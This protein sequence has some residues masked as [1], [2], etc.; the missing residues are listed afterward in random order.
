MK[1]KVIMQRIVLFAIISLIINFATTGQTLRLVDQGGTPGSYPTISAAVAAANPGD[2]IKVLSGIYPESVVIP[3]KLFVIAQDSTVDVVSGANAFT[4]N[5]GSSGS[6]LYG[7]TLRGN[8]YHPRNYAQNEPIVIANNRFIGTYIDFTY[9]SIIANNYFIK[10]SGDYGIRVYG[11]DSSHKR[12]IIFNNR[13]DS[14]GIQ[15]GGNYTSIIANTIKDNSAYGIL[16]HSNPNDYQIIANKI[17]NCARGIVF[18][19]NSHNTNFVVSNNLLTNCP[20]GINNAGGWI[21]PLFTGVVSNNV[22]YNSSNYA[23]LNEQGL[24]GASSVYF[25]SNIFSSNTNNVSF[26]S[27]VWDYN[28][29]YNSGTIPTPGINNITNDPLFVNP[30]NGDFHLLTGSPCI[31]AGHPTLIYSDIDRTR[32]DMGIYGGS[33]TMSNYENLSGPKVISLFT[34]PTQVLKGNDII[35]TGSGISK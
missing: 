7:F 22:V 21:G 9:W 8:V 14:C 4:F 34:S 30:S 1:G 33:F 32:N 18:S 24:N 13:L 23:V 29:F 31:D 20:I 11:S 27:S 28:C 17:S 25:Y 15:F 3:K 26:A 19:G 16:T 12:I 5:S 2:T 35:I 10:S 6:L